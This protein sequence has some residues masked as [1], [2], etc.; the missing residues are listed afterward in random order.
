MGTVG[1]GGRTGNLLG[2]TSVM[3]LSEHPATRATLPD[4]V[5]M[6]SPTLAIFWKSK[7]HCQPQ[8]QSSG[9]VTERSSSRRD[10]NLSKMFDTSLSNW[11][12]ESNVNRMPSLPSMVA[13]ATANR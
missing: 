9:G 5:W 12:S 6:R 7:Q 11:C 2:E 8:T 3:A 1:V 4:A 10:V 13:S